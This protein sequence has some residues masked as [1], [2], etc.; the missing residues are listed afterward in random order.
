MEGPRLLGRRQEQHR[1][2][3][4]ERES[5]VSWRFPDV[6]SHEGIASCY[7]PQPT[8]ASVG[9]ATSQRTHICA[10]CG[11]TLR[12][13]GA[14][15]A[16]RTG[17]QALGLRP[18]FRLLSGAPRCRCRLNSN[19]RPHKTARAVRCASKVNAS[20]GDLSNRERPVR[21]APTHSTVGRNDIATTRKDNYLE[22]AYSI[23]APH[24][25]GSYDR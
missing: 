9:N 17:H 21:P 24:C 16:W 14:P 22:P 12:S 23:G 5:K 1:L 20:W 19:V 7:R 4:S 13:S 18:I 10:K 2:G 25:V 15:T 3:A 8:T 11:L 6:R